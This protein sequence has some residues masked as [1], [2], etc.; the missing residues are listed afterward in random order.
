M[1]FSRLHVITYENT[2][3]EHL[4]HLKRSA[5]FFGWPELTVIGTGETWE[6]FGTKIFAYTKY[7]KHLPGDDIVV[8]I[9]ARDVLIN[10]TPAQFLE[11]FTY[12]KALIVSAEFGCCAPGEPQITE[13]DRKW[14]ESHTDN[15]NRYLNSGMIAGRVSSFQCV[16]PF[17]VTKATDDDQNAMVR[18]WRK[19]PEDIILDYDEKLFSNATWSPNSNGYPLGNGQWISK[20]S[21]GSPIFIQTQ[22]RNWQ[23]YEKLLY[24]Y[25][26]FRYKYVWLAF[27]AISLF[28][29]LGLIVFR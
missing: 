2:N 12:S 28:I 15:P 4:E 16:Y 17:G 25:R 8:L 11:R 24:L 19:N 20:S 9:D 5:R 6:G 3:H 14:M 29:V 23:C 1:A 13:D 7:L 22:A 18:Y 27:F 10:G 21:G 26:G